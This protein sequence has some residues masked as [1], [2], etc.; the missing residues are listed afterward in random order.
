MTE[1]RM[2]NNEQAVM[3]MRCT[4]SSV[5]IPTSMAKREI[6]FIPFFDAKIEHAAI[7]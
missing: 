7:R 3:I 1:A 6:L 4:V 2:I 5:V